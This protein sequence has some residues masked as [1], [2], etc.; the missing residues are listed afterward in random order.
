MLLA[1][2]AIKKK[3]NMLLRNKIFSINF[4]FLFCIRNNTYIISCFRKKRL[5]IGLKKLVLI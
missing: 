2:Y 1:F 3:N 5:Y 4:R